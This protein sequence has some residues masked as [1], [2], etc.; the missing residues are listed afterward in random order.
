VSYLLER[1]SASSSMA[2]AAR[3]LWQHAQTIQIKRM[4]PV[5]TERGKLLPLHIPR[6]QTQTASLEGI[7]R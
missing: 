5:W 6:R 4:E 3:V 1:L 7:P 2:D